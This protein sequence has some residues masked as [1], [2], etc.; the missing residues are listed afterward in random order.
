MCR[1]RI[2][3]FY[4][5]TSAVISFIPCVFG[6]HILIIIYSEICVANAHL[7]FVHSAAWLLALLFIPTL[8]SHSS[9]QCFQFL[10]EL[11]LADGIYMYTSYLDFS[12][13]STT[14]FSSVRNKV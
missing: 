9:A 14:L 6:M 8:F 11:S 13:I 7:D 3:N 10:R 1:N 5:V 12:S 4:L 2:N